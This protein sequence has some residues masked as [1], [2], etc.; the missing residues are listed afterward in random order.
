ML[1]LVKEQTDMAPVAGELNLATL[2]P[3]PYQHVG[4]LFMA[5]S[6][7]TTV[8][9]VTPG[10]TPPDPPLPRGFSMDLEWMD[11][12]SQVRRKSGQPI[13]LGAAPPGEQ[14][15]IFDS[16]LFLVKRLNPDALLRVL[17]GTLNPGTSKVSY[18]I[19]IGPAA[20]TDLIAL[21]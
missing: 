18:S 1:F 5:F 12:T 6:F 16:G 15:P 9:D 21:P 8:P 2:I 14:L 4:P 17:F 7:W 20:P 19:L 10:T 11:P 13:S 3:G